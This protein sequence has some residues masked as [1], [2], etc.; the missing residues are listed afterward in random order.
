MSDPKTLAAPLT[1]KASFIVG[2]IAGLVLTGSAF[3]PS[4]WSLVVGWVGF[5][6]CVL[7]GLVAKPPQ[8]VAGKPLV[9]GAALTAVTGIL[10]VLVQFYPLIPAGW[11]QGVAFGVAGILSWLA[12]VSLPSLGH[13]PTVEQ[14]T[15]ALTAGD[16]AGAAVDSK[17]KALDVLANGAKGPPSP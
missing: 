6:G 2:T 3:L 17:E 11:P 4:P 14:Q 7:A 13:A 10:G 16:A 15:Q 5:I 9:Q 12:G 8:A 1:G